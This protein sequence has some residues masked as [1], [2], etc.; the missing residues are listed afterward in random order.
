M[1]Y[2]GSL[3]KWINKELHKFS[4]RIREIRKAKGM[5]QLD[6]ALSA[7]IGETSISHY[8]RGEIKPELI[9]IL[10]IAR[11]LKVRAWELFDYNGKYSRV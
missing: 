9:T 10:G 3:E 6:V 5:V 1:E 2:P 4:K 11:G 7:L 8:E